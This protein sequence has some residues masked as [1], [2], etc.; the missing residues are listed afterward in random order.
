M[1]LRVNPVDGTVSREHACEVLRDH[2]V[3]VVYTVDSG[4]TRL[5]KQNKI[6]V[7]HFPERLPHSLLKFLA[8]EFEFEWM[9]FYFTKL[10]TDEDR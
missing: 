7:Q 9:R 4:S 6:V 2:G 10:E 5:R 3:T 8:T 1:R